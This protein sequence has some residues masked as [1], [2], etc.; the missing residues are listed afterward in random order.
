MSSNQ[1]FPALYTACHLTTAARIEARVTLTRV[2]TISC[3]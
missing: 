2:D 3:K 1:A